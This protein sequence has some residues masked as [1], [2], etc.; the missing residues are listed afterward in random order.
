MAVK[1][2]NMDMIHDPMWG[3]ILKFALVYMLTAVLQQLYSAADVMIVGRFAGQKALAGVGTCSSVVSLF[4]NFIMGLSAGTTVVIGQAIGAGNRGDIEKTTH[5]AMASAIYG[6]LIISVICILFARPLLN[7]V[8]VPDNVM[9]EALDYMRIF[10][11]GFIPSLVYNFGAAVLRAKGD[12]KRALYIVSASGIINVVL[13][14]FFVCVLK[15]RA[16]GVAIETVISQ[17]FTAV[18]ILYVLCHEK[19]ETKVYLTKIRFWRKPFLKILRY[20]LP[21]GIQSS[22]YSVSNMLVQSSVNSFGSAAIAGGAAVSNMVEFYNIMAT[23]L[24]QSARVFTSQ[25]FGAKNF[26]RIKRVLGIC[27]TYVVGMWAVQIAI[28][29]VFGE[30]V[31]GLYVPNDPEALEMGMRKLSILGYLYGTLGFTNII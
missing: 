14:L 1:T 23:G 21:T 12:T 16:A 22:V 6:G 24:Y 29:H 30:M 18:A 10:S 20:G 17:I 9:S 4:F 2:N 31:L 27:L 25:N 7:L 26:G 11:I 15:M 5:T 13:N 19:D 28:T 8:D 3:K